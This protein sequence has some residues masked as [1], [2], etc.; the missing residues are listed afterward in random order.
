MWRR[1]PADTVVAVKSVWGDYPRLPR[2]LEDALAAHARQLGRMV[3]SDDLLLLAMTE[4]DETQ[5]AR[6][7]LE[8]EGV[9][10]E[11]LLAAIRVGGDGAPETPTGLR[12]SPA[13]YSVQGRAQGFA[14]ALGDGRI[15]A[16]HVLLAVLW[17][18][19]S[20]SSQLLWRLGLS[21][22]RLVEQLHELAVPVPSA[23]LPPQSEIEWGERVWFERRDVG[24]V[25]DHVRLHIHPATRWG[26]NYAGERAWVHAEASVDLDA[27][28]TQALRAAEPSEP[29]PD[30]AS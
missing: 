17:D 18:P 1:R 19:V 24:R 14:A 22:E 6:R 15:T 20:H 2:R 7:A 23:P 8:A 13:Y 10:A 12:Y 28:V 30:D 9:D 3:A 29:I 11:R 5:P 4:L 26:F 25:L 27:L 21:R 16:E